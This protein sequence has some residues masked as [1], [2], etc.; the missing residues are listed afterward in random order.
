MITTTIIKNVDVDT[1]WAS[2]DLTQ[3][4]ED[5]VSVSMG[6]RNDSNILMAD[7][8][9]PGTTYFTLKGGS[10]IVMSGEKPRPIYVK[11]ASGTDVLELILTKKVV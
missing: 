2:L 5:I 11:V 8:A 9:D 4:E 6:A 3:G 1:D 7:N 10:S